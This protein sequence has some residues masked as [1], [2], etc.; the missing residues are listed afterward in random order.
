MIRSRILVV[1]TALLM[2]LATFP[3]PV[4]A[5]QGGTCALGT[6]VPMGYEEVAVSS[7][8]I[9]F[10]TATIQ[11]ATTAASF[12]YVYVG[13]NAVRWRD[14]GTSP[15][16]SVGQPASAGERLQVCGKKAV[17]AIRF[18]RQSADATIFASFYRAE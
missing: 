17:A 13:S 9:G 14:D 16:A 2:V 15:T 7:T 1:I 5:Q 18:I 6:L 4:K 11:T 12:A 8:A 10:T 3:T